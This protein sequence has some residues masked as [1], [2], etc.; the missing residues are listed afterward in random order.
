MG[1]VEVFE[2]DSIQSPLISISTRSCV[3]TVDNVM[4]GGFL[5]EGGAPKTFLIRARGGSLAGPPFNN[6]SVLM[7]PTVQLFSGSTVIAQNDD[8]QS[9]DRS[10]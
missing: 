10:A 1:L 4:I 3:E 6:P 5:V 7:N 2:I 8:W 9:T